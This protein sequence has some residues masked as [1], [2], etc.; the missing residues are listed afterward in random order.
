MRKG[1]NELEAE[2]DAVIVTDVVNSKASFDA[3]VETCGADRVLAPAL[4]G[5]RS[6]SKISEVGP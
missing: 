1:Y 4:L 5:L 6:T 3:A 2:F